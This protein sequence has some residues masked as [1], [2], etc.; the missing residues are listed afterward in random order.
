MRASGNPRQS[1]HLC[2]GARE[3]QIHQRNALTTPAKLCQRLRCI[4]GGTTIIMSACD[5][6]IALRP[7][8]KTR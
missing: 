5:P 4:H 1:A 6:I 2:V 8:G 7:S 3:V